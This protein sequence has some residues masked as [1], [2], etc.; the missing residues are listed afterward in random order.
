MTNEQIIF[1]A[2]VQLMEAG[3]IGTTGRIIPVVNARGEEVQIQEPVEMHTFQSWKSK[4]YSVKRG[5]KAVIKLTIW[6]HTGRRTEV[7]QDTEGNRI[8][9]EDAGHCFSKVAAF[10]SQEQVELLKA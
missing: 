9:Q 10:F 5:E 6:K 8:E 1:N 7:L 4:G 2:R 3:K